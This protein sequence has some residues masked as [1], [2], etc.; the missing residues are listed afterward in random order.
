MAK[1]RILVPVAGADF[2]WTPEQ[3]VELA[4]EEAAKWADG[5]RAEVYEEP[6]GKEKK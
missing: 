3:V 2:S 4:D 6:K 5:I 1:I